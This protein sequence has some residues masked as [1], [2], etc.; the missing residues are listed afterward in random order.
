MQF[1]Y[2]LNG[3]KQAKKSLKAHF[4]ESK[5]KKIGKKQGKN[6]FRGI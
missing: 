1:L 5:L 2:A 6:P 4:Y 3:K